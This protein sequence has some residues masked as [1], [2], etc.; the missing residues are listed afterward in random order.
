MDLVRKICW[1]ELDGYGRCILVY[2]L[3]DTYY[4]DTYK[5]KSGKRG[6]VE[7]LKMDKEEFSVWCRQ[8]KG[9]ISFVRA[10]GRNGLLK[11]IEDYSNVN[12]S[13]EGDVICGF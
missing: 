3:G 2:V 11:E 7:T 10:L 4:V 12:L 8:V 5:I 9:L 1:E 6:S 13:S